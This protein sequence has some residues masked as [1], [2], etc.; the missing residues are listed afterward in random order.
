MH[1]KI[2]IS[3]PGSSRTLKGFL[4]FF[5]MSAVVGWLFNEFVPVKAGL[6]DQS[7]ATMAQSEATEEQ[8]GREQA[9]GQNL[10]YL[11]IVMVPRPETPFGVEANPFLTSGTLLERTDDLGGTWVRLMRINW[12][13][14]QPIEG[15]PIQWNLLSNFEEELRQLKA[16][17]MK[18]I[19]IVQHSP[20][21]A[22]INEP[23][24]TDCG[25][26]RE[27]KFQAFA[28]FMSQVV[29]R[30][31]QVYYWELNNEPD[32]DP[33]LVSVDQIYGCWGKKSEPYYNG[34]QYGKMLKVVTPAI[35]AA[36][37]N[38]KVMVGGLLLNSPNTDEVE[39][40]NGRPELFLEGIIQAGLQDNNFD[41]FDSVGYHG[42]SNYYAANLDYTGDQL[43]GWGIPRCGDHDYCKGSAK[44]K[45]IW[46]RNIM[47]KY[48]VNKPLFLNE[49]TLTCNSRNGER[50]ICTAPNPDQTFYQ[51]QATHV[52]R[53]VA[54]SLN[55][56]IEGFIWYTINGPSW[57]NGGLLDGSSQPRPVY[58]AYK[59]LIEQ[60]G[61]ADNVMSPP[62]VTIYGPDVEAYRF[63][64]DG[65]AIDVIW[66]LTDS[67]AT[68]S[69]PTSEYREAYDQ[70]G[71]SLTGTTVG[72]NTEFTIGFETIYIHRQR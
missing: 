15:G 32:V 43:G 34:E 45:I 22:T 55:E 28:D 51:N 12:R 41:Y 1:T 5:L 62:E 56:G 60:I 52:S 36:N 24:E 53:V 59:T 37:P 11:P 25:A 63:F 21:W 42:H 3:F 2:P 10:I 57:E 70:L 23:F 6:I 27:D 8:Q 31:P 38:A 49:S 64:K 72:T 14:L 48:G 66:A 35:R 30:Y 54:R 58:H 17:Q 19:I 20:R 4:F 71:N 46:L 16:A 61:T 67:G 9:N 33:T 40:E 7:L 47:Q 39:P 26:I 68:V 50:P 13:Q 65:K 44:G 18:P 29:A 69:L